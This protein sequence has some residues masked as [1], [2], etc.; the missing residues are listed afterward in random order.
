[1]TSNWVEIPDTD[2]W[3]NIPRK[4]R[5]DEGTVLVRYSSG[6]DPIVRKYTGIEKERFDSIVKN[7]KQE[8]Y[9]E[10]FLLL[11]TLP[12]ESDNTSQIGNF[13]NFTHNN[14]DEM[15]THY[16]QDCDE[17]TKFQIRNKFQGLKCSCI[18]CGSKLSVIKHNCSDCNVE[19]L[20]VKPVID[21]DKDYKCYNC[22]KSLYTEDNV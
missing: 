3:D 4:I 22:S 13:G 16:C 17:K 15:F 1:M 7:I 18:I 5:W 12:G 10:L 21:T 2:D 20:F 19:S 6:N 11:C 9:M 14:V 8:D